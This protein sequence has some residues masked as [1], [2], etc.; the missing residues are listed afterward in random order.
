MQMARA[1]CFPG[2]RCLLGG[3]FLKD[4]LENVEVNSVQ[5]THFSLSICLMP[6][7][8]RRTQRTKIGCLLG[9]LTSI[10][11]EIEW[12]GIW[13]DCSEPGIWGTVVNKVRVT[14]TKL[15]FEWVL[16]AY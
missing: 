9:T 13:G 11:S 6:G 3:K 8:V 15:F 10:K 5:S 7:S 16:Y 4:C 1:H 2:S 12:P 14:G